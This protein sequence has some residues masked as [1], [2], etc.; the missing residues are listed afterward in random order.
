MSE[1]KAT[2]EAQ[3]APAAIGPYSVAHSGGGLVF[4]SGQIGLDPD[5]GELVEGGF[6]AEARRVFANLKA[7]C[8]AAGGS[9]G[10]VVKLNVYMVD[11]GNF[12]LFNEI[13]TEFLDAPYPARA[14]IGVASLPKGAAVEVE[15]IM[16]AG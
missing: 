13:A 5:S 6:E 3:G 14:A 10:K 7:V 16:A 8:E 9:L 1:A 11:L 4:L 2:T 12:A 15:G